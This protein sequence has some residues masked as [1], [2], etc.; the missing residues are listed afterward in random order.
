[1]FIASRIVMGLGS[2]VSLAGAAQLVV[3]LAY[4][5]ERSTIVGLFQA[6]WYA[7]SIVAAGVT[8]GTYNWTTHWSWRLPTLL[9]ILPS[10]FTIAFIWYVPITTNHKSYHTLSPHLGTIC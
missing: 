8:L 5:K 4:P 2:P 3:E 9:Q 7:G 1:M 6:T 10:L